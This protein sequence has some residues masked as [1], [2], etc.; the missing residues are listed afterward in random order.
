M[1]FIQPGQF[2][3][4]FTLTGM[5]DFRGSADFRGFKNIFGHS[6]DWSRS[7]EIRFFYTGGGGPEKFLMF[8]CTKHLKNN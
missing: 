6:F 4:T 7:E 5:P 2:R 1:V 8:F 3:I